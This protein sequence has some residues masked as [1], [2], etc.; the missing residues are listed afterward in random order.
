MK[1]AAALHAAEDKHSYHI[2]SQIISPF[3]LANWPLTHITTMQSASSFPSFTV[4]RIP[5]C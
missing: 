5:S 2:S 4:G 1:V 3:V